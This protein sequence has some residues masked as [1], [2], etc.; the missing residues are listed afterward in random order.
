MSA[1][2]DNIL[3]EIVFFLLG[4]MFMGVFGRGIFD[5]LHEILRSEL[6][7]ISAYVSPGGKFHNFGLV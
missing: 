3:G 5:M 7:R 4:V 1:V 6:Q 2:L